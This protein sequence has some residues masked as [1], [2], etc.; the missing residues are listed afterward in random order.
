[1]PDPIFADSRLAVVYDDFDGDRDDLDHYEAIVVE[2]G[3]RRVLDLGCGT[4]SLACRLARGGLEVIGV[5][6]AKASLDVARAKPGSHRVT[7]LLGHATTLPPVA[8]DVALMTGNVAQVFL[9]DDEWFAT[10]VG[11]RRVL[12]AGGHLVFETRDPSVRG[13]QEWTRE[14]SRSVRATAAG[15]VEHWVEDTNVDLPLV[16]FRHTYRFLDGGDVIVSDSTLRFR[17]REEIVTSLAT[18]GF[19]VDD[20]RDAPDRPGLE[21]VFIARSA[22]SAG[23][24]SP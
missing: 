8:V 16:S 2:F 7:W 23:N 6:P 13:W 5:D 21:L 3:A 11:I 18:A 12:R 17:D 1:M 10:L 15:R 4:G 9:H 19:T 22:S 14:R 20:I 24:V